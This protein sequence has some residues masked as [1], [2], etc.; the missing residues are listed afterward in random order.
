LYDEL[1][2]SQAMSP[3][4]AT[5][6]SDDPVPADVTGAVAAEVADACPASFFAVTRTSSDDPTSP[7]AT[8]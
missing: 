5:T 4:A 8:E 7:E 6:G 1:P 2:G 3:A